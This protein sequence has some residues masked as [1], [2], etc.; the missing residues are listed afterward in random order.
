MSGMTGGDEIFRARMGDDVSAVANAMASNVKNLADSTRLVGDAFKRAQSQLTPLKVGLR[1]AK[2]LFKASAQNM[3]L[4]K[5]SLKDAG[6]SAMD[7][8][9]L[10]SKLNSELVATRKHALGMSGIW[11]RAFSPKQIWVASHAL[12]VLQKSYQ[13][14][15]V[16]MGVGGAA[17]G[18]LGSIV[19]GARIRQDTVGAF[20]QA[21]LARG[22][23]EGGAE[24]SADEM[25]KFAQGGAKATSLQDSQ[26]YSII[27][28]LLGA[29]FDK[30]E[31]KIHYWQVADAM[32]R[33]GSSAEGGG[34]EVANRTIN[35]LRMEKSLGINSKSVRQFSRASNVPMFEIAKEFFKL[36]EGA[37]YRAQ[38]SKLSDQDQGKFYEELIKKG[39]VGY[40]AGQQAQINVSERGNNVLG[41]YAKQH[42][43]GTLSGEMTNVENMWDRLVSSVDSAQWPGMKSLHAFLTKITDAFDGST[44]SGKRMLATIEKV[45]N[46]ILGCLDKITEKDIDTAIRAAGRALEWVSEKVKDAWA[47]L[48]KWRKGDAT[49]GDVMKDSLIQVGQILGQAIGTGIWWGIKNVGKDILK[50]P[51]DSG[52]DDK[53]LKG[54]EEYDKSIRNVFSGGSIK[55]SDERAAAQQRL[56]DQDKGV[57]KFAS[58]GLVD[59]PTRAIVGED[60]AELIVPLSR[61]A[62]MASGG[63]PAG[64]GV[65]RGSTVVH[66][67]IHVE[68]GGHGDPATQWAAMR[69]I[70]RREV[71]QIFEQTAA[72]G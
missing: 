37:Q 70:I 10:V 33:G 62:L 25:F 46:N 38:A 32:A 19:H 49:I 6:V 69:P 41:Q 17:V 60:G 45:S 50:G 16:V 28:Q 56:I 2:D 3:N 57:Q 20:K 7:T 27:R 40:N 8:K 23:T 1:E 22:E 64:R 53:N 68:G 29:G 66:M 51:L 9:I 18:F 47:E 65:G 67:P 39:Q 63:A 11:E 44:D 5:A 42:G 15:S 72:E 13:A 35:A 52:F 12:N 61:R 34:D 58:G 14:L 24:K 4:F 30:R 54:A 48:D 71:I 36:P 26:S 21:F 31:A 59:R 55:S 43:E